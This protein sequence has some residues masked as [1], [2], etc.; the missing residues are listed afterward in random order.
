M[1]LSLATGQI[2]VDR[3]GIGTLYLA[4]SP[5]ITTVSH[6]TERQHWSGGSAQEN[7]IQVLCGP[8]TEQSSILGP[9]GLSLRTPSVSWVRRR[10][11]PWL[12][13][14]CSTTYR[15]TQS[16]RRQ[17]GR[18]HVWTPVTD[19]SRMPS[20]AWKKKKKKILKKSLTAKKL[21][22]TNAESQ[23]NIPARYAPKL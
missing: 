12:R 11:P 7:P 18:A 3:L 8:V 14:A 16:G 1:I 4:A 22:Y 21:K 5:R 19:Q 17:I 13:C 9:G 23:V 6:L 15:W 2:Q 20:S 10:W